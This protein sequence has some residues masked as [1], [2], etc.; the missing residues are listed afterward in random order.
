M[1]INFFSW[2]KEIHINWQTITFRKH[3]SKNFASFWKKIQND[4][5]YIILKISLLFS[6]QIFI[7]VIPKCKY[8]LINWFVYFKK[9]GYKRSI[10]LKH[11]LRLIQFKV[12]RLFIFILCVV[13]FVANQMNWFKWHIILLQ[14]K[15]RNSFFL[16]LK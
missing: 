5:S 4:F 14:K 1:N 15:V 7:I 8:F 10:Y 16:Y 3:I 6:Y 13:S 11:V 12:I 9:Y 2:K